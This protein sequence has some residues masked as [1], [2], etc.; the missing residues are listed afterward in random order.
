VSRAHVIEDDG[1]PANTS[2]TDSDEPVQEEE[3]QHQEPDGKV[4][5]TFYYL[6]H[7]FPQV[8]RTRELRAIRFHQVP[9]PIP[10]HIQGL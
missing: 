3:E 8:K 5:S 1:Q 4:E 6:C 9:F 10:S 7:L 2:V